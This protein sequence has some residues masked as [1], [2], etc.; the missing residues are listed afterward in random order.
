MLRRATTTLVCFGAILLSACG[1][2]QD[3]RQASEK[4]VPKSPLI[5]R[6]VSF[7]SPAEVQSRLDPSVLPWEVVENSALAPGDRR[8][9]FHNYVVTVANYSDLGHSGELEL[10]FFNDRLMEARFIPRNLDSYLLRLRDSRGIDLA[11]STEASLPPYTLVSIAKYRDGRTYV[12]W[13]D[14]R[15]SKEFDDWIRRY[16]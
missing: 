9:P 12:S 3:A 15:L 11:A 6:I 5:G 8:P 2:G 4:D 7:E 14:T 16:S 1:S 13:I 10:Y